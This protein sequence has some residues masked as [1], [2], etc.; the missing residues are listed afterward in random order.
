MWVLYQSTECLICLNSQERRVGRIVNVIFR[1]IEKLLPMFFLF[2]YFYFLL[3]HSELA[4]FNLCFMNLFFHHILPLPRVLGRFE[5][6]FALVS[7]YTITLLLNNCY[8]K[9]YNYLNQLTIFKI[10]VLCF[11]VWLGS[12]SVSLEISHATKLMQ[13]FI[14]TAST[15]FHWR[16][17]CL[18]KYTYLFKRLFVLHH[19]EASEW[20]CRIHT[21]LKIMLQHFYV[22]QNCIIY[23]STDPWELHLVL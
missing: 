18:C 16:M 3:F 23:F 1:V 19:K 10:T 15:T 4:T 13:Q 21:P 9:S 8:Y 22:G 2:F 17:V 12:L 6:V 14:N 11:G 20:R 7:A 5:V